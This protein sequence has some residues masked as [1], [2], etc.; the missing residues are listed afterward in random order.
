MVE[1]LVN[2]SLEHERRVGCKLQEVNC[3]AHTLDSGQSPVKLRDGT[4]ISANFV[5]QQ[6]IDGPCLDAYLTNRKEQPSLPWHFK[7]E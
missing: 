1:T 7:F 4:D 3:V 5:V 2:R 6:Y